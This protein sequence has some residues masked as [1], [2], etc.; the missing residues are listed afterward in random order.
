METLTVLAAVTTLAGIGMASS[1]FIQARKI[2]AH[3]SAR[4]V[5]LVTFSILTLGNIIWFVYGLAIHNTPLIITQGLG[6]IGSIIVLGLI[7]KFGRRS[8]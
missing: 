5:S 1:Y 4:D 2:W 8:Q 7:L 3:Q 6:S